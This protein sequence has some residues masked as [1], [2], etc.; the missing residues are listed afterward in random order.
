MRALKALLPVVFATSAVLAL[1]APKGTA[2]EQ[3]VEGLSKYLQLIDYVQ[4]ITLDVGP[5]MVS[6]LFHDTHSLASIPP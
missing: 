3:A 1:N 4:A 6:F 5:S 2:I